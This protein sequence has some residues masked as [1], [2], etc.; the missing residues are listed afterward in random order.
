MTGLYAMKMDQGRLARSAGAEW[1]KQAL[2]DSRADTL[3]TLA[4]YERTLGAGLP[5]PYSAE[6]NPPLWEL[7]HIGWFQDVWLSRNPQW[8]LGVQADPSIQR[9]PGRRGNSDALYDSS[10]VPH[11]QRWTLDLPDL[12]STRADLAAQLAQN[13]TLLTQA[14]GSAAELYFFRLA[15]LHEDMHHEAALYMAQN[16]G[17]PIAD[18]RWQPQALVGERTL[19]ALSACRWAPGQAEAARDCFHFDNELGCAESDW[20]DLAPFEIDLRVLSWAEYLAFVD[21]GGYGQARWWSEAGRACLQGRTAPRYLRRGEQG[22][23]QLQRWGV[24][25]DLTPLHLTQAAVHLTAYEAEAWCAWAGRRLP[26]EAEWHCAASRLGTDFAWGQ[27]WEWTAS[28]FLPFSGFQAHPYRDYSQ[29]W[30]GQRR[31]L[32]GASL[33]T[34]PRMRHLDYRNFFA[35]ARNDIAAGFRS[36]AMRPQPT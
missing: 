28:D 7:G 3:Q 27:V 6:L 31:V 19:A 8:R 11:A 25:Q 24:W 4:C 9:S 33:F 20:V 13:L 21:S 12:S 15:L 1:L 2:A 18:P 5:V 30:F 22:G 34:Q 29:P 26:T 36:C 14:D 32:R 17:I 10:Q 23:W 16:L 35:P